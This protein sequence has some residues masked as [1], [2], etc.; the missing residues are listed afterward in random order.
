MTT[1]LTA[2]G[3]IF[4]AELPD[5]TAIA[6]VVL[7][8]RFGMRSVV[9][10]GWLAFL[11]QTVVAVAAGGLLTL[12]PERPIRLASGAGFVVFA[13]LAWRRAGAEGLRDEEQAEVSAQPARQRAAWVSC[14]LVVFA[15]EWGDLTQLATAALA[16]QTRQPLAVGVGAL[17]ALWVVTVIA[18]AA[19]SSLGRLVSTRTLNRAGAAVFLGV[20]A[21][22]I[23][24]AVG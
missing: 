19:G 10:G 4:L 11:V 22:V 13:V 20:G 3:V 9:I 16:A 8:T 12:L 18:A 21:L 14:F 1:L 2:F 6:S 5:K 7:A 23:A 17:A 15:A 24:S